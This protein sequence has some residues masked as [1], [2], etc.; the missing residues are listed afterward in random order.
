MFVA[1]IETDSVFFL[2]TFPDLKCY[3]RVIHF[4]TIFSILAAIIP[5]GSDV[6]VLRERSPTNARGH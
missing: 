2:Y 5:I 3:F 6:N 4:N 1:E